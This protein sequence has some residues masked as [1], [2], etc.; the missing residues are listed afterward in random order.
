MENPETL[1]RFRDGYL[2]ISEWEALHASQIAS[3]IGDTIRWIQQYVAKPHAQIGREGTVCPKV[4]GAL[5]LDS[6]YLKVL[7]EADCNENGVTTEIA[8]TQTL[9]FQFEPLRAPNSVF[10]TLL[11]L[12]PKGDEV[13]RRDLIEQI[14]QRLKPTFL[15]KGLLLG[16]FH[17][18]LRT[19]ALNNPGFRPSQ[20]PHSMLAVRYA[21]ASDI[22]F[23]LTSGAPVLSKLKV[24]ETFLAQFGNAI[25]A[26]EL[27]ALQIAIQKLKEQTLID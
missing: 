19:T 10:K 7:A 25:P 1:P 27:L 22:R 3:E 15:E 18:T 24:S 21:V 17:K 2:T 16:T 11:V 26:E 20:S 14:Q 6:I 8:K 4:P 13:A 12:L 9:F 5:N 23:V